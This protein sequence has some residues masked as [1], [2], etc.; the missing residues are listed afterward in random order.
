M[1]ES[2]EKTQQILTYLI[3]FFGFLALF[4]LPAEYIIKCHIDEVRSW[5]IPGKEYQK[6]SKQPQ[7]TE[8]ETLAKPLETPKKE[9]RK[10][11]EESTTKT[12]RTRKKNIEM[13]PA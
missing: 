9:G 10:E 11:S 7:V 13:I 3:E 1:S 8:A 12:N 5:G 2:Y 6:I 4:V